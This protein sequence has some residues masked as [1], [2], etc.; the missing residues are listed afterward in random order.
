[1]GSADK[2][3]DRLIKDKRKTD[4]RNRV[5]AQIETQLQKRNMDVPALAKAA[6]IA[7]N[8]IYRIKR[9]DT[10]ATVDSITAIADAFGIPPSVLLMP[11]EQ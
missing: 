1:M 8:S 4:M 9:G 2:A 11:V 10:G 6:G 3:K 7:E 5:A